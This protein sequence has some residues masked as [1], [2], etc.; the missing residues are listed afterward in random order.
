MAS[1]MGFY[2]CADG[3][4]ALRKTYGYAH[5]AKLFGKLFSGNGVHIADVL[6]EDFYP[7]DRQRT[8]E[9]NALIIKNIRK[10]SMNLVPV[11]SFVETPDISE[12]PYLT[13]W[14]PS[15]EMLRMN[16][17]QNVVHGSS[18]IGW[19][20]YFGRTPEAN[21]S[22]M[23]NFLSEVNDL[24]PVISGAES[25]NTI[26]LDYNGQQAIVDVMHRE[27]NDKLY[28]FAVRRSEITNIPA[29][30]LPRPTEPHDPVQN[31]DIN[32][33]FNLENSNLNGTASVL[34]EN[35]RTIIVQGGIFND[36]FKPYEVHIYSINL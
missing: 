14:A 16:I 24:S 12:S 21:F 15:A 32:V 10:E 13:P 23:A 29:D 6:A 11:M 27:Y 8:F 31:Y 35:N 34:K 28:I 19:F 25:N 5:N 7:I 9:E 3:M 26:S 18:I 20:H 17:W 1:F 36:T 4:E 30:V 33:T 2:W 22:T